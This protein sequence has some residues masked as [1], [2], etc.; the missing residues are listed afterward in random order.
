MGD[1]VGSVLGFMGAQEQANAQRDAAN[2]SANAQIRAAQMAADAS[3]FRPVGITSRFGSSNFQT[4]SAGN[5][6]GAGYNVA[7]DIAAIRDA[8][9]SQA[10]GQGVQTMGQAQQFGQGLLGLAN[11]YVGQSPQ[12][13]A[14]DYISK[15]QALLQPS[16]ETQ[17]A[18][19]QNRLAQT[20]RS[21]LSI[22]QGGNLGAANPELQAYYNALAQQDAQLAANATQEAR[23]QINFGTGL[24]GSGLQ[25]MSAGTAPIQTGVGLASTLEQ[26][27]QTPLDLGAQLGGRSAQAGGT[28]ANALLKGGLS[29]AATMQDVNQMSPMGDFLQNL[30]GNKQLRSGVNEWFS[31]WL[32]PPAQENAFTRGIDASGMY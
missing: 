4:D 8:L 26:L 10:G 24:F 15:Q 6:V 16:R 22:A 20:G 2:A 1:I 19:I 11:Q 3:R 18:A 7:P 30:A 5:L 17:L 28:A 29:A 9:L 21:G 25:T 23:N 27:G 12:A 31:N 13:V 32:N 14:Q